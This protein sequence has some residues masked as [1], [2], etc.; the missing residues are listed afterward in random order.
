MLK[1]NYA[2]ISV[3]VLMAIALAACSDS[4]ANN[5]DEL[6]MME[7]IIV[8]LTLSDESAA[9]GEKVVMKAKVTQSGSPVED[10]DKVEFELKREGGGM[11][12]KVPVAHAGDGVYVLEKAFEEAGTYMVISHV[13]A[14]GQH[15]MPMKELKVTE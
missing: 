7:P 15:S 6:V 1:K 10:A 3:M 5:S 11:Q 12:V 8:D 9:A 4:S 13:T 14:R 2:I